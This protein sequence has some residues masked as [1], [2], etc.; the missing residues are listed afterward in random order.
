MFTHKNVVIFHFCV[1]ILSLFEVLAPTVFKQQEFIFEVNGSK[2]ITYQLPVAKCFLVLD[3]LSTNPQHFSLVDDSSR[4]CPAERAHHQSSQRALSGGRAGQCLLRL[5]AGA[6][7]VF[8][9]DVD[10]QEHHET[11]VPPGCFSAEDGFQVLNF[12]GSVTERRG[13]RRLMRQGV[14]TSCRKDTLKAMIAANNS[15]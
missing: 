7:A 6:A 2:R 14:S 4:L 12:A 3:C 10:Y 9:S 13:R 8:R 11:V 15:F 1:A 5:L